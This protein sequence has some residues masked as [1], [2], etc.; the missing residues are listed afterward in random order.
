MKNFSPYR[1]ILFEARRPQLESLAKPPRSRQLSFSLPVTSIEALLLG[2]LQGVTEFLP[3]SSSGHL[4][5]AERWLELPAENLLIFDIAAHTGTLGALLLFF[6][7]EIWRLIQD[8][9]QPV[10]WRESLLFPLFVGTIPAASAGLL[11]KDFLESS[12]RGEKTVAL[13]LLATAGL[14]LV[15]EFVNRRGSSPAAISETADSHHQK[16]TQSLGIG[17]FQALAL[18]P[19]VS[20]SG[21]TLAGGLFF[22]LERRAA[23]R[24]SF[25]LGTAA[26]G[27]AT[28]LSLPD[29]VAGEIPTRELFLGAVAAFLSGLAAISFFLR[30]L[31]KRWVL[32][33]FASYLI[34]LA[35]AILF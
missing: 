32:P 15:G 23:A 4:V 3:V 24:F 7:R 30:L 35:G 26:I 1:E 17:F 2:L 14:L 9:F 21:A 34:L 33:A 25:L 16:I 8:L 28:L 11:G 10:R 22:G 5:L 20:R 18:I 29:F 31:E 6:R 12:L 27:G 19:G 13:A